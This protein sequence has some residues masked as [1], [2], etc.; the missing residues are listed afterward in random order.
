MS[1]DAMLKM[2][3]V[4]FKKISDIA[5]YLFIEKRLRGG[6]SYI[7]KRYAKASNKY[8]NDYGSKK[9]SRFIMY[10]D[11]N[12]LYGWEMIEYLGYGGFKFLKNVSGFDV[13]SIS[14]K[15]PIG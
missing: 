8:A 2:T 10:I 14:E 7:A 1:F 5:K 13:N 12:S 9:L 6:I 15:S 3:G 4:K 11:I